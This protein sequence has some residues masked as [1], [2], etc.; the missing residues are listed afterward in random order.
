MQQG[1][2]SS[3]RSPNIEKFVDDDFIMKKFEPVLKQ[4]RS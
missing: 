1:T 4:E 3:I 2:S